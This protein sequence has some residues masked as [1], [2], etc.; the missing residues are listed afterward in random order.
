MP[1]HDWT[2]VDVG[3]FHDFHC[4]WIVAIRDCLNNGL[5]PPDYYAMAERY[6]DG[7]VPDVLTLQAAGGDD[8]RS[9][10]GGVAGATAVAVAP[11]RVRTVS[12]IARDPYLERQRTIVVRHADGDRV[13]ALVEVVSPGNKASRKAL[14][15]F[16]AKALESLARGHHLLILDLHPPS[17]RDPQGIHGAIWREAGGPPH[18][19]PEDKPLTLAAYARGTVPTAYVEPVAV[20]D[21]LPDMPLF[22]DPD[23]YVNVPLE[24]TYQA[25]WRGVGPTLARRARRPAERLVRP[26][27]VGENLAMRSVVRTSNGCIP[28]PCR[29]LPSDP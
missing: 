1:I 10:G 6:D 15:D 14:G 26:M 3:V 28:W 29:S 25:A 2:R 7:F 4:G 24:A 9:D 8:F 16:V 18:E 5:L 12:A 19:P 17:P 22:L 11:P 13:V 21:P 27:G 20:A 23:W